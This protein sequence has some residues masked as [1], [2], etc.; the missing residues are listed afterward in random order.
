M[1]STNTHPSNHSRKKPTS[2]L[3]L[4]DRPPKYP[5]KV[6]KARENVEAYLDTYLG[7]TS[8]PTEETYSTGGVCDKV[9]PCERLRIRPTSRW[10]KERWPDD[11]QPEGRER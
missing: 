2:K 9:A 4:S 3:R 10:V 1:E 11:E 7:R 8:I 6:Q 5:L